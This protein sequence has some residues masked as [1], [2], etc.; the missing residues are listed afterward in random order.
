MTDLLTLLQMPIPS[1]A[2]LV[3]LWVV[4]EKL[5]LPVTKMFSSLLNLNGKKD[6]TP[7]WAA[8]LTAH[9]NEETTTKLDAILSKQDAMKD[10]L[11]KANTHLEEIKTYGV[12]TRE[13]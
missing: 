12:L 6:E 5:G 11:K 9:F 13:K 7:L 2:G 1:L 4:A 3:M 8:S 10:C